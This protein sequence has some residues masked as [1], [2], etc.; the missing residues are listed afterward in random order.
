MT[1]TIFLSMLA[2]SAVALPA[3]RRHVEGN[4]ESAVRVIA[5]ESLACGDCAVYRRMLDEKLLP[6]YGGKVAFEH[7]DFPLEKQPWSRRAAVAARAIEDIAPE[8]SVRFRREILNDRKQVTSVEDWVAA[9]ARK[10]G[11]EPAKLASALQDEKY[12]ALVERDHQDGVARGVSRT[13][14]VF[15]NGAPFIETFT[16]EELAKAIE[17]ALAAQ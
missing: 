14:T 9:W 5:F 2:V 13:P 10:N 11:L 7:R 15:V 17:E 3:S 1:R 16:F 12:A 4:P 6:K 8:L